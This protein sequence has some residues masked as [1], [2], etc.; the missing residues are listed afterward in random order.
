MLR[1]HEGSDDD[2]DVQAART[3]AGSPRESGGEVLPLIPNAKK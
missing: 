2:D 3:D 1:G